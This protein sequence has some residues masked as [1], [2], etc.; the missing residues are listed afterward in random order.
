MIDKK[1]DDNM[2]NAASSKE[3]DIV[4]DPFRGCGTTIAATQ[5]LNRQ[6]IGI[7]ITHLSVGLQKLRLRDSFGL[8]PLHSGKVPKQEQALP[9]STAA[10]L[11]S[12]NEAP[13]TPTRS[14]AEPPSEGSGDRDIAR[15][16][17]KFFLMRRSR[18]R[19]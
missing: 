19:N 8:V 5:K 16:S 15:M 12:T 3:G 2:G 10:R 4:L 1:D 13:P 17:E 7:D 18:R 14:E 6:W 11:A 9:E